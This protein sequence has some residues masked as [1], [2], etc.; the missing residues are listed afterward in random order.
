MK[1]CKKEKEKMLIKIMSMGHSE[2]WTR[3]QMPMLLF[4]SQIKQGY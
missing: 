2:N 4:D 3:D 1:N